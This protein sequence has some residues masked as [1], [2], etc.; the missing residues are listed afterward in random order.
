[1]SDPL[2]KRTVTMF[3]FYPPM[4]RADC[5]PGSNLVNIVKRIF[6]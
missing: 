6:G 4:D 2:R 1:V 3:R 5:L